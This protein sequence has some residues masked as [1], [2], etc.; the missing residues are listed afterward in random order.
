M[1]DFKF[2]CPDCGQR[3]QCDDSWCGHK[4]QCPSC[5][6]EWLVPLSTAVALDILSRFQLPAAAPARFHQQ[7]EQ[8]A[9]LNWALSEALAES[10]F[11]VTSDW[12]RDP[13]EL[14][15]GFKERLQ[16]CE[17]LRS[18][19]VSIEIEDDEDDTPLKLEMSVA[20]K[21]ARS[22]HRLRPEK[23]GFHDLVFSFAQ[24]LP[25][26]LAIHSLKAF[27]ETDSVVY[28]IGPAHLW[29]SL[30]ETLSGCFDQ[31]F[32]SHPPAHKFQL[33]QTKKTKSR[34]P[35]WRKLWSQ[36]AGP[37][38]HGMP[39]EIN[40]SLDILRPMSPDNLFYGKD[41]GLRTNAIS[42]FLHD[43][44][45]KALD[46]WCVERNSSQLPTILYTY[47]S[48]A[49]VGALWNL[50]A[51]NA[52]PGRKLW[53]H[54]LGRGHLIWAYFIL[55]ALGAEQGAQECG[56]LLEIESVREMERSD[57][58][59]NQKSHYD[60]ALHLHNGSQGDDLNALEPMLPMLQPENWRSPDKV[61]GAVKA[62]AQSRGEQFVHDSVKWTWP[63]TLYALARRADALQ[64]LPRD[65]P[66]LDTPLEVSQVERSEP[67][68]E[69]FRVLESR[70]RALNVSF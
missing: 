41:K 64:L 10:S 29:N 26:E 11:A 16:T 49:R 69:V 17:S 13:T 7:V 6:A 28:L 9:S 62:H 43:L 38:S 20:G 33:V 63:A 53:G 19:R 32:A 44:G 54:C 34:P 45:G 23:S 67:W 50:Y 57:L 5:L 70:F 39:E 30:R 68:L 59:R 18:A 52:F 66:F 4:L 46:P 37:A 55:R 25:P 31:L 12:K 42:F 61:N 27:E 56:R 35:D 22:F 40:Q 2:P 1:A 24:L 3:I 51:V 36:Y 65:N 58:F 47:A 8:G 48:A 14:L 21:A 15:L 60:L